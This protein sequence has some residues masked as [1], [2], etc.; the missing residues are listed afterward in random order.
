M[1]KSIYLLVL[2]ILLIA[3]SCKKSVSTSDTGS[4]TMG[5][6]T[7]TSDNPSVTVN[8]TYGV[9]Y[10]SLTFPLSSGAKLVL[11][12]KG[13]YASTY[14]LQSTSYY[15]D[16]QGNVYYASSSSSTIS[17]TSY[18]MVNSVPVLSG[19]FTFKGYSNTSTIELTNGKFD[20]VT[21]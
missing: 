2:S 9:T 17:I 3:S 15:Q 6:A 10:N 8:T 16:S 11:N 20:K 19:T 5:N 18:D 7:Y 13:S 21:N 12:F 1:K 14:Y 4:W